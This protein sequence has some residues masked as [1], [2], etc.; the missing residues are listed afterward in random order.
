M[1]KLVCPLRVA[2]IADR[3]SAKVAAAVVTGAVVALFF[4]EVSPWER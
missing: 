2:V 1:M 4:G 3:S